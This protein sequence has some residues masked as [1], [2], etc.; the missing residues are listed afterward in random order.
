MLT[1]PYPH[2]HIPCPLIQE[3]AQVG[4][5]EATGVPRQAA[6]VL[7]L[8]FRAEA[9]EPRGMPLPHPILEGLAMEVFE[10]VRGVID[11]PK[12]YAEVLGHKPSTTKGPSVKT[13]V[14]VSAKQC[15]LRYSAGAQGYECRDS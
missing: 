2:A 3:V 5:P 10:V 6:Q 12:R 1:R 8:L 13:Q 4:V 14:L 11:L 9:R 15:R 7:T